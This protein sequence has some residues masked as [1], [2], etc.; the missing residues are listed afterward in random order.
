MALVS[1]L[2]SHGVVPTVLLPHPDQG[3]NA[4]VAV[5]INRNVSHHSS[6]KQYKTFLHNALFTFKLVLTKTNLVSL[7]FCRLVENS[8][9]TSLSGMPSLNQVTWASGKEDIVALNSRTSSSLADSWC[10][11]SGL[12]VKNS[13]AVGKEVVSNAKYQFRKS[14][15]G[16]TNKKY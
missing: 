9:V 11:K 5:Q 16:I 4:S 2:H 14:L 10:W 7:V 6:S 3:E 13:P 12:I 8:A 1:I 15:D